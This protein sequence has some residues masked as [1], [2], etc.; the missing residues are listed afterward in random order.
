VKP[1]DDAGRISLTGKCLTRPLLF[2]SRSED[3]IE[4]ADRSDY[5]GSR[6]ASDNWGPPMRMLR[7]A[8]TP[9]FI[10]YTLCILLTAAP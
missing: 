4:W 5:G 7:L 8:L 2:T 1:S 3:K 6:A 10:V 9:R